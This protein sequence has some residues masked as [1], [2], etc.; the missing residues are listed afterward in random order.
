M[1]MIVFAAGIAAHIAGMLMLLTWWRESARLGYA[2]PKKV[3]LTAITLSA[4][5]ILELAAILMP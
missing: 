5:L 3:L 4:G 2:E 1:R